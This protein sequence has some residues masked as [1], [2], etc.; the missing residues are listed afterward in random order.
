MKNRE[1]NSRVLFSNTLTRHI[2]EDL[3]LKA[4]KINLLSQ[5]RSEL[6]RQ[7]HQVESLNNCINDLKQQTYAQRLELQDAQHWIFS[8]LDENKFVHKKNYL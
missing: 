3:S 1:I 4:I 2:W 7:E 6:M 5:A 8:G